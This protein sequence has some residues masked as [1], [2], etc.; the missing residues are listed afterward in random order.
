MSEYLKH[1]S[2]FFVRFRPAW[3]GGKYEGDEKTRLDALRLAMDF[4][5][6]Y[7]DVEL[8]VWKSM[9]SNKL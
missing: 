3:E 1:K 9:E 2:N 4:G 7:I 6:D 5:A 8:Q